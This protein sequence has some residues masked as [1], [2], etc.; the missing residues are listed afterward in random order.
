MKTLEEVIAMPRNERCID[1]RDCARLAQFIF[2]ENLALFGYSPAEGVTGRTPIAW[3]RENVLKQLKR[4][5]AFGFEKALGRRSISSDLMFEV[6]MMWNKILEE[7]LE[8][9]DEDNYENY[10]LPLFKATA[11]KYGFQNPIGNDTG[12]E[13]KY[14]EDW[15]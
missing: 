1:V 15:S 3:T 5:V 10:G 12:T 14:Y 4:D 9:F 13:S 2:L 8:T 7:G 11:V 6:V